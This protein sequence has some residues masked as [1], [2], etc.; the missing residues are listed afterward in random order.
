MSLSF[1][2]SSVGVALGSMTAG[3]ADAA[4]NVDEADAR[5]LDATE[6]APNTESTATTVMLDAVTTDMRLRFMLGQAP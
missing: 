6:S 5:P 2:G 4:S 1:P 3:D